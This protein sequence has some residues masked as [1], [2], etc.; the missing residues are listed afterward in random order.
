MGVMLVF[1]AP[2]PYVDATSSWSF[3]ERRKRVLVGAAGMIAELFVAALATFVWAKTAPGTLHNLAYNMMF[4]A[5]VSTVILN[6]NPLLRYDGYYI[7][8]DLLGIPNLNQRANAQLTYLAES[9]LFGAKNSEG[10]AR[11]KRE[12][13]W[14]IFYGIASG[15]YCVIVFS[16]MLLVVANKF[17]IIG[18]VM[19]IERL[20]SWV[21]VPVVGFIR[22]LA[23]S[24]K[25][26]RVRSR[27]IG[28]TAEGLRW[29]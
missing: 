8:S 22:Y 12:A 29:F 1:F 19:V 3:R 5:S 6:I 26:D 20:I 4:V 21:I 18:I 2:L 10:P 23:T 28:V 16:G 7:L 9:K 14:L 17:L 25:L 11:T 27:A 13:G 15:I 24:P